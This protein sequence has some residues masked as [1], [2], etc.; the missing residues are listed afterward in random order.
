MTVYAYTRVS[1]ADN[2]YG[3]TDNQ[4]SIIESQL[5]IDHIYSDINISGSTPFNKRPEAQKMVS[6]LKS[7]DV[8]VIAKLDR[9][10]RDTADCLNTIKWLK[11]KNITLKILDI[12][13]DVSTP[14]GEMILTIMASVATFERKRIAERIKDGF[15]YGKSAGKKYGYNN[16]KIKSGILKRSIER[17][18]ATQIRYDIIKKH[19]KEKISNKS[20]ERIMLDYLSSIDIRI[21]RSTLRKILE[22]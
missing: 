4:I 17:K 8:I 20:S 16:E 19:L 2:E 13:L 9:G 6:L 18:K 14:I 5:K 15:S 11:Q 22:R 12:A 1:K 21:S 3:T 7:G 10:F